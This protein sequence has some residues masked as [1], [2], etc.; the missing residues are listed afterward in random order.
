MSKKNVT[1]ASSDSLHSSSA[2]Y[3]DHVENLFPATLSPLCRQKC[4]SVRD[5]LCICATAAN[6]VLELKLNR[7]VTTSKCVS[8]ECMATEILLWHSKLFLRLL[9]SNLFDLVNREVETKRVE[10]PDHV[11][12]CAARICLRLLMRLSDLHLVAR[13]SAWE[14][15]RH[16]LHS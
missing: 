13:E 1:N 2:Q 10:G 15:C 16:P 8:V 11:L 4:D 6:I 5:T 12:C 9:L 14:I 7:A 3:I